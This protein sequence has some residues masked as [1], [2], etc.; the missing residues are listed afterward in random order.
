MLPE[1]P[2]YIPDGICLQCCGCC[3]F[4]DKDNCWRPKT[5]REEQTGTVAA[6]VD[7]KGYVTAQAHHEVSTPASPR[8][9]QAQSV[10][11]WICDFLDPEN[12][13]CAVYQKRPFECALYPFV[14]V[15]DGDVIRLMFHLSC[16][17][18]QET[19]GSDGYKKHIEVLR[20]YFSAPDV[21]EF[22]VANKTIAGDYAGYRQELENVFVLSLSE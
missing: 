9:G 13:Y 3:R 8:G 5:F 22:L 21:H 12:N 6:H 16:P 15:R 19:F 20:K 1:L 17:H 4:T 11:Q 2:S 18:A 14:F 10:G 7:G